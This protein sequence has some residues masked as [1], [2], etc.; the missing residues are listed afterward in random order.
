MQIDLTD[1][2]DATIHYGLPFG[3]SVKSDL[4]KLLVNL[5]FDVTKY[6]DKE[7]DLEK[8]LLGRPITFLTMTEKTT[9]GDFA[10]VVKGS[11]TS[12]EK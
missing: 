11:V 8:I 2:P 1:I 7:I 5:G 6:E 10:K 12:A 3:V 9:K 4:G